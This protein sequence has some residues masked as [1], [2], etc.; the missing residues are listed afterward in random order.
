VQRTKYTRN[1]YVAVAVVS[2]LQLD[3]DCGHFII[4]QTHNSYTENCMGSLNDCL[5]VIKD[6]R[7]TREAVSLQ[8]ITKGVVEDESE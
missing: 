2:H 3:V 8:T 1:V 7:S 4:M 6:S 5:K